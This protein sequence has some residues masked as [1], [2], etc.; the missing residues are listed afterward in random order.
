MGKLV[1]YVDSLSRGGAEHVSVTVADYAAHHGIECIYK[2]CY[3]CK[4]YSA[5][6]CS[7][8]GTG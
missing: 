1:I 3:R 8:V 7:F 2:L 5:F 4:L 6:I